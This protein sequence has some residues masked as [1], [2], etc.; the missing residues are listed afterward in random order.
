MFS[1]KIIAISFL[2]S[3]FALFIWRTWF[4]ILNVI[5]PKDEKDTD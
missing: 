2:S 3:F 4:L 1:I 5:K